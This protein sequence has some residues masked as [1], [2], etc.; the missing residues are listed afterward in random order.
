MK[1]KN[2]M[3]VK[4]EGRNVTIKIYGDIGESWWR[5]VDVENGEVATLEDLD[6]ILKNNKDAATIDIYINSL[7]GDVFDGVAIYNMLKRHRAY[8]RV[9]IEGFACS[10]AS[11]IAMA[12]NSIVMPKTSMMMIHNAWTVAMGNAAEFRKMADD[13]DKINEALR[14]AYLAKIK[15]SD[16]MLI[17]L[18][19]NESYLTADECYEYGFCTAIN[20]DIDVSEEVNEAIEYMSGMYENK[21]K[22]LT[23]LKNAIKDIESLETQEG[24]EEESPKGEAENAN[25]PEE[26]ASIESE[27]DVNENEVEKEVENIKENALKRFF[28]FKE[29]KNESGC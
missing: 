1:I 12:G 22:N 27:P 10:V 28:N 24:E 11:V 13:L 17:E 25:E 26:E 4:N 16:E 21:L 3:Q 5:D 7:G 23:A 19:N 14:N 8:K 6:K 9:F 2:A 18:M 20:D 29:E 15:I